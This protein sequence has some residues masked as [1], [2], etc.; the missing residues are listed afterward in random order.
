MMNTH[1]PVLGHWSDTMLQNVGYYAVSFC[2]SYY[3]IN[4]K[5]KIHYN[6]AG[7]LTTVT[8]MNHHIS[9]SLNIVSWCQLT[10]DYCYPDKVKDYCDCFVYLF[11]H[12]SVCSQDNENL[13]AD[14][15][16]FTISSYWGIGPR[17]IWLDFGPPILWKGTNS[18]EREKFLID[19][20]IRK[21]IVAEPTNLAR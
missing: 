16:I 8:D 12:P 9:Y 2:P 1:F 20:S 17:R 3:K 13:W 6:S 10:W 14:V 15:D 21:N 7:Q 19:N 5:N 4:W 18:L 11:I